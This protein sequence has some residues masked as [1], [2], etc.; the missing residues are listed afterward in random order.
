MDGNRRSHGDIFPLPCKTLEAS[1]CE[2]GVSFPHRAFWI[3]QT[4]NKLGLQ[5]PNS[6]SQSVLSS[7]LP[8]NSTQQCVCDRVEQSLAMHGEPPDGLTCEKALETLKGVK[9]GYDGV[10]SNLAPFD[11]SKLK[12]LATSVAP[13]HIK[14]FLPPEARKLVTSPQDFVLKPPSAEQPGFRPYWDPVLR[15]NPK[16]RLG[17]ILDLFKA[18]LLVLRPAVASHVGV[19]FVK[20]KSPDAIRMVIDC[21]GTNELCQDPP[22]TRLGSARCYSDLRLEQDDDQSE[23]L[24]WGREADVNDCF[25]RFSIPELAHY[26]GINHPLSAREWR[27]HGL[28]FDTI[29]DPH[30][31]HDIVV[32]DDTPLYPCFRAVPMGWNWA[33]FLCHEAVLE[34]AQRGA[35][36]EDGVLREK[37]VTPQ[38]TEFRTILGVYVDNITIL[39]KCKTDV[40]HRCRLLEKA[41]ADAQIP[42]TWS[43]Q[44]AVERLESVGCVLDLKNGVIHNKPHRVWKFALA[45][46]A[47]LKRRKLSSEVLQVWTGHFTSLCSI[48]P[49][50]LAA[51]QQVY[52]FIQKSNGKR[53]EVWPSVRAELK[54]ASSLAWLTW[55]NLSAPI[56]KTVETGDASTSGYALM[57]CYPDEQLTWQSMRVHEKWRFISMPAGLKDAAIKQDLEQFSLLLSDLL[58]PVH[59]DD[60]DETSETIG[61]V[62]HSKAAALSTEY[63]Q[64]VLNSLREGSMLKTSAARAQVHAKPS[65]RFDLEIPALVQPLD[66]YFADSSKYRLLWARR[67]KYVDE[68][69][70]MKEGRVALSSL[71]RSSRVSSLHGYRKLTVSDNLGVVCAFSKGRSSNDKLNG[72]CRQSASIQFATGIV[73]H[74]RH[75][76]TT[77]NVADDPSRNHEPNRSQKVSKPASHRGLRAVR[78]CERELIGDDS[79]RAVSAP[80]KP[81]IPLQRHASVFP[82]CRGK[83]F[84]EIFSGGGT[85]T[86]AV[87]DG[88]M[89]VVEP[90]D[91]LNG[92]HCDVRRKATQDLIMSWLKKGVFGFVHLGTPCTIWSQARHGVKES[93]QT[94][95][96]EED[97]LEMALFSAKIISLCQKMRIPFALENPGRSRL[98]GFEPLLRAVHS[99]EHWFVNFDMCQYGEPWKKN[100]TIVTSFQPLSQLAR[101]CNH[102]SHEVWL[103]GKVQVKKP[104]GSA[105]YVNRTAL[106]GAY[107]RQLVVAY[108]KILSQHLDL[109]SDEPATIQATWSSALRSVVPRKVANTMLRRDKFQ[110]E[111][112]DQKLTLLAASGDREKFIDFIALGRPKEEAWEGLKKRKSKQ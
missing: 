53:L 2:R 6:Y 71:K 66:D 93:H 88:G 20:K 79:S 46:G 68:N 91:Y 62:R 48:T 31:R 70:Q 80:S 69:I 96:K 99:G 109:Y 29:Y 43:Q 77:R 28:E 84:L 104:D 19:F 11:S 45:T 1:V 54:M 10:P 65:R 39:G 47:L 3:S 33:L 36:W 40:E 60:Q 21:R 42:I 44:S 111:S 58:K 26:F 38:L 23:S 61:Y 81:S 56:M 13:Q 67:W 90:I 55:R 25:Y 107:P 103:K 30:L 72:L 22:T 101:S 8:L 18:G 86:K 110:V 105:R 12:I 49:W 75:I 57:A 50:G 52:R 100:T 4:L 9:T 64:Q 102:H 89:S 37:R 41:F 112:S 17:F 97:G 63:G 78:F 92:P 74:L 16:K 27:Q 34:I 87:S 95:C 24:A 82:V 14:Q 108:S 35:P 7:R 76:E 32:D 73:W 5:S 51:L 83:V 59:H 94:R 98:F 85:L 15:Y 106:A